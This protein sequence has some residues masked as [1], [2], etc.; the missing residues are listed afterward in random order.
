MVYMVNHHS[1]HGYENNQAKLMRLD[2]DSEIFS[3]IQKSH[4][5]KSTILMCMIQWHF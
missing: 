1:C 4:I 5:M 2:F 3:L